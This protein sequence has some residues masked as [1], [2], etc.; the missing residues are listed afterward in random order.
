MTLDHLAVLAV[1]CQYYSAELLQRDGFVERPLVLNGG[2]AE[3]LV[4]FQ[5]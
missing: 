4:G 5:S 3:V 1:L 2:A